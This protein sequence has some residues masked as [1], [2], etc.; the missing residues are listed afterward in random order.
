MSLS[1]FYIVF[2]K[3]LEQEYPE[4]LGKNLTSESTLVDLVAYIYNFALAIGGILAFVMLVIGGVRWLASAGA[5][6]AIGTAKKQ[7]T[8]ALLG[9]VLLLASYLILNTLN[10]ELVLLRT[11]E[12]VAEGFIP[13]SITPI[14]EELTPMGKKAGYPPS[15]ATEPG[16]YLCA[17]EQCHGERGEEWDFVVPPPPGTI[18]VGDLETTGWTNILVAVGIINLDEYRYHIW[19]YE[20]YEDWTGRRICFD[21]GVGNLND[22]Q[23]APEKGWF[24]RPAAIQIAPIPIDEEEVGKMPES[25]KELM[26][27]NPGITML[28]PPG[29]ITLPGQTPAG[30]TKEG[31]YL[32]NGGQC[33]LNRWRRTTGNIWNLAQVVPSA[34]NSEPDGETMYGITGSI[35]DSLGIIDGEKEYAVWLFKEENYR[36]DRYYICFKESVGTLNDYEMYPGKP[37]TRYIKSVKVLNKADCKYPGVTMLGPA[38]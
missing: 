29:S 37:W 19:L 26:C 7:I 18:G 15:G 22:Y 28:G 34:E 31:V 27:T 9:L 3:E 24:L 38:P 13:P 2:A 36:E 4:V 35:V 23:F 12:E 16:I 30:E 11:P 14:G 6:A 8:T 1:A 5:P 21:N 20:N 25:L 33:S 32:C 10:P 17:L